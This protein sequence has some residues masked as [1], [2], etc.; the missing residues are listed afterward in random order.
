MKLR[1]ILLAAAATAGL[2]A[3]VVSGPYYPGGRAYVDVAIAP[4]PDRVVIAPAVRPGYVWAPGY[5]RWDGRRHV[6]QDGHYMRERRG[7]HWRPSHW[8]ERNGRYHLEEGHWER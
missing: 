4:P 2:S 8:E 5:W 6:W 3:C 7:Y 1:T